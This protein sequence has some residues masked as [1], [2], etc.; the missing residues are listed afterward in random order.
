MAQMIP[1]APTQPGDRLPSLPRKW[2]ESDQAYRARLMEFQAPYHQARLSRGVIEDEAARQEEQ[3]RGYLGEQVG[4]QKNRMQ[5]LAALLAQQQDTAFN[6]NIP[7]I[8]ETAQGGGFLETSGFGNSLARNYT[9]LQ[10]DT[11]LALAKQ[12]LADRDFEVAGIGKIADNRLGLQTGGLERQFSEEDLTRSERLA[13][14][15]GAMGVVSPKGESST[16]RTLRQVQMGVGTAASLASM[17][18]S[19]K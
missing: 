12:G 19:G 2:G 11:S 8:A 6:R 15:L 9:D 7:G 16:D 5:E 14:E 1:G 18:G 4:I 13:R 10:E 3:G 17:A